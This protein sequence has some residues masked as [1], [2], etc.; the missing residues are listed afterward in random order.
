MLEKLTEHPQCPR[1]DEVAKTGSATE[2]VRKPA[3][4]NS[5][6][7]KR[8]TMVDECVQLEKKM[9]QVKKKLIV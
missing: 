5:E 7:P 6:G 3:V 2:E 8:P 4:A 1:F 9:K